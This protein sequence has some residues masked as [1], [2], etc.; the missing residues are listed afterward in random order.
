MEIVITAL[1]ISIII[2][3]LI[4]MKRKPK[5][6]KKNRFIITII[7]SII[8]IILASYLIYDIFETNK[9]IDSNKRINSDKKIKENFNQ[10]GGMNKSKR[11]KMMELCGLHDYDATSHCFNDSTHHTCCLLGEKAR[12]YSNKKNPIGKASS[13]AFFKMHGRYPEKHEL[14]SWCTCTGSE[15]CSFYGQLKEDGTNIKFINNPKSNE[16]IGYLPNIDSEKGYR[17]LFNIPG[18]GTPGVHLKK[19]KKKPRSYTKK[20]LKSKLRSINNTN[21][22]V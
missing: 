2:L 16:E 6:I 3:T 20:E 11:D 17:K 15:V 5:F 18:H 13:E 14:T 9:R 22:L 4:V 7:L 8:V 1:I 10:T 12:K 21:K 19:L